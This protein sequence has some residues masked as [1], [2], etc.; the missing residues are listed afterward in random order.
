MTVKYQLETSD[1]QVRVSIHTSCSHGNAQFWAGHVDCYCTL[2]P[3]SSCSV[4]VIAVLSAKLKSS[5]T[6]GACTTLYGYFEYTFLCPRINL[7]RGAP[8]V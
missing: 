4:S 5:P 6:V 7:R 3:Y 8:D 2:Q 1:P